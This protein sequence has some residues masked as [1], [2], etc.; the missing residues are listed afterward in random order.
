MVF[1]YGN[2]APSTYF[3]DG[4]VDPRTVLEVTEIKILLLLGSEPQLL[5]CPAQLPLEAWDC[6]LVGTEPHKQK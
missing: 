6:G 1:T 5:G 4:R 2:T 3:V